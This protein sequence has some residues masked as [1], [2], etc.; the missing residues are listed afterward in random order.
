VC[1]RAGRC[2]T[3]VGLVVVYI[4]NLM[5][6]NDQ[7]GHPAVDGCLLGV[8][9]VLMAIAGRGGDWVGGFGGYVFAV[10]VPVCRLWGVVAVITSKFF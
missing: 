9:G 3:L 7:Q 8:A 1:N 10:M 6:F 4:E 2:G 5:A